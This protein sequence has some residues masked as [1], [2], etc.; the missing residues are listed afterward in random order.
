M[1][2]SYK[3]IW[4]KKAFICHHLGPPVFPHVSFYFFF[5]GGGRGLNFSNVYIVSLFLKT[6]FYTKTQLYLSPYLSVGFLL[7]FLILVFN[8]IWIPLWEEECVNTL[9]LIP[10]VMRSKWKD[11][12]KL[13]IWTPTGALGGAFYLP[14]R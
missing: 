12:K 7:V 11:Q 13:L 6:M 3:K 9:E 5:S 1:G 4:E 14:A 10:L 2:E 8:C